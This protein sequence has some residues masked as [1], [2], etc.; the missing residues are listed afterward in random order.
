[1]LKTFKNILFI[2]IFSLICYS[3]TT[4]QYVYE[5]DDYS[6]EVKSSVSFDVIITYGTPYYYNG[7][8][9]YYLYNDIYYYPYWYNNYWYVRAYA[10]PYNHLR[11]RPHFRPSHNDYRFRPGTY[12]GYGVPNGHHNHYTPNRPHNKRP[13]INNRPHNVPYNNGHHSRSNINNRPHNHSHGL[14]GRR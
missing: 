1:M 14:G 11:P 3:C 4:S 8:I 12:R 2:L 5:Y 7:S 13:N 10:R 9:L 6:Y